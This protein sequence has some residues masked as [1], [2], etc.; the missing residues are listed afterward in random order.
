V[1][2]CHFGQRFSQ[3]ENIFVCYERK[4]TFVRCWLELQK[5]MS[6][7]SISDFKAWLQRSILQ[8]FGAFDIL[9]YG[10]SKVRLFSW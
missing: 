3:A 7:F 6:T 9:F 8:H 5:F 10:K 2:R 4:I 1:N